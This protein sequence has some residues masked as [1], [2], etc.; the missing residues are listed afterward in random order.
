MQVHLDHSQC[1]LCRMTWDKL[2]STELIE[3]SGEFMGCQI[4]KF[5]LLRAG[6]ICHRIS[7]IIKNWAADIRF[8]AFS[9]ARHRLNKG[10]QFIYLLY[11]IW[12]RN[13]LA[14]K[15]A[16]NIFA[17]LRKKTADKSWFGPQWN[18]QGRVIDPEV[19]NKTLL[20]TLLN[21]NYSTWAC[22]I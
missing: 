22:W 6:E 16:E 18:Q 2:F 9:L 8:L 5:M 12:P 4:I 17:A 19:F 11:L 7:R 13:T 1:P 20:K 10:Y 15:R 21:I 14:I 3:I